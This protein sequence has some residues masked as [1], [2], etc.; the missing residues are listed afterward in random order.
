MLHAI[1]DAKVKLA[2]KLAEEVIPDDEPLIYFCWHQ[3]VVDELHAQCIKKGYTSS[4]IRGGISAEERWHTV[5]EFQKGNIQRLALN[6]SAG[7]EGLTLHK[8]SYA[9]F[10]ELPWSPTPYRQARDRLHR[11]GTKRAVTIYRL[12]CHEMDKRI[13]DTLTK[14]TCPHRKN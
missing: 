11:I 2:I 3:S 4:R 9:M 1:G 14:R 12:L 13:L 5:E 8:A 10:V 7:G 6:I